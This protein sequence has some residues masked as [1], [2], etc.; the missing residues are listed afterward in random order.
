MVVPELAGMTWQTAAAFLAGF[1]VCWM[2][3]RVQD[4]GDRPRYDDDT[5][6]P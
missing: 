4:V 6:D 5:P 1:L 3:R 2:R